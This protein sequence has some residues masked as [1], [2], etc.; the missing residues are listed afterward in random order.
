MATIKLITNEYN[1][2]ALA[3][4]YALKDLSNTGKFTNIISLLPVKT[5]V[6][7]TNDV[8]GLITLKQGSLLTVPNSF[9]ATDGVTPVTDQY[10]V[11]NDLTLNVGHRINDYSVSPTTDA[12]MYVVY[13]VE[14]NQL[15]IGDDT[16]YAYYEQDVFGDDVD[17]SGRP[18][19]EFLG[20]T[21]VHIAF[22][23]RCALPIGYFDDAW[24]W[25]PH[26]AIGF[27]GDLIWVDNGTEYL[28]PDGRSEDYGLSSNLIRI[29]D[30][31]Y[32]RYAD[33]IAE[34]A[35]GEN[36][37]GFLFLD[38]N[39]KAKIHNDYTSK[40]EYELSDGVVYVSSEN[41]IYDATHSIWEVCKISEVSV[42]NGKFNS[43]NNF[44]IYQAVD[45]S[46]L[47]YRLEDID[48]RALHKDDVNEDVLGDKHFLEQNTFE[49]IIINGGSINNVNLPGNII[50][51]STGHISF[52]DAS[53]ASVEETAELN[54][55]IGLHGNTHENKAGIAL[56]ANH[57]IRIFGDG[58]IGQIKITIPQTRDT[59]GQVRTPNILPA[60]NNL[61]EIGSSS[62][63]FRNIYSTTFTGTSTQ[64]NWA[65][66]AEIYETDDDYAVGTLLRWGGEKELTLA[67]YGVANAVVS[68]APGLL[69]NV[70][71]KGQPIALVGRVKV[72]VFGPI[73]KHDAIVLHPHIPG[74]GKVQTSSEEKII[75]RALE[76]DSFTGEKLVLCVVKFT[77]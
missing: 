23:Q 19:A 67:N 33:I 32:T 62:F 26:T 5:E 42:I 39:G 65:D 73:K 8:T 37:E 15:E 11:P 9:S 53:L 25:H 59:A 45:Y 63:V 46:E 74:I 71:G 41:L 66:L 4:K 72:R 47:T 36:F 38:D 48:E 30:V 40:V 44:N 55:H 75:A 24:H 29:T 13:N 69:M 6:E 54:D 1:I 61:Y 21:F 51:D 7:I 31:T 77:L 43:V 52:N 27:F 14:S 50:V 64:T 17:E 70:K 58:D 12:K 3:G 2:G 56:G 20:N 16:V 35:F 28:I 60:V 76:D 18:V 22:H 34:T 49:N 68:E 10:R 57:D